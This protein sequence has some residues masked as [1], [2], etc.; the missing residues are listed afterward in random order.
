MLVATFGDTTAWVGKTIVFEDDQFVLDGHG[1]ITSGAI[2]QYD[3]QGHLTWSSTGLRQWVYE[4]AATQAPSPPPQ[5]TMPQVVTSPAQPAS[6]GA[7]GGVAIE[8]KAAKPA[9]GPVL[10]ATFR[11][12]TARAGKTIVHD[13]DAFLVDGEDPMTAAEVMELDRSHELNWVDEGTRAW[14]GARAAGPRPGNAQDG[15][16]VAGFMLV[17][18]GFVLP[19]VGIVGWI[20]CY[21]SLMRARRNGVPPGLA[22]WGVMIGLAVLVINAIIMIALLPTFG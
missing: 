10:I 14:V 16:G 8:P 12:Q 22:W 2:V 11:E 6:T 13:R 9:E 19:I 21:R 20:I 4:R 3:Q 5:Q 17:I 7:Q 1:S 18:V 15:W